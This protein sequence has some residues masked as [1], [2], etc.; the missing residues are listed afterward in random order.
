MRATVQVM[1]VTVA[2]VAVDMVHWRDQILVNN[3][4]WASRL[5]TPTCHSIPLVLTET[6]V[7]VARRPTTCCRVLGHA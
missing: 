4:G 5:I 6:S 1:A 3:F 2:V 7:S